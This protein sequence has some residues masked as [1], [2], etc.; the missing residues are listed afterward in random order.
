MFVKISFRRSLNSIISV[1][2]IYV[3]KIEFQYLLLGILL[4][5]LSC[6]EHLFNLTL[7][8]NLLGQENVSRKLLCYC[9]GSLN[10]LASALIDKHSSY[11]SLIINTRM[12]IEI[13]ILHNYKC[14]SESLWNLAHIHIVHI[15][16]ILN[17]A[18]LITIR[19][20]YNCSLG[21]HK[22]S[23]C[24]LGNECLCLTL[25]IVHLHQLRCNIRYAKNKNQ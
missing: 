6:N 21:L 11:N 17:L 25:H 24:T 12:C 15:F 3:I 13:L 5:Q 10:N 22:C 8:R 16:T 19:I 2:E 14:V 23:I 4:F 7:P 20:V 9:T 1:A 18:E